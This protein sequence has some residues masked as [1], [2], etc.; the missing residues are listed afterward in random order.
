MGYPK[1]L[2]HFPIIVSSFY[3]PAQPVEAFTENSSKDSTSA[4]STRLHERCP[5]SLHVDGDFYKTCLQDCIWEKNHTL[6]E[7]Q[8]STLFLERIRDERVY[9][10]GASRSVYSISFFVVVILRN[11][12]KWNNHPQS[13]IG[14][15]SVRAQSPYV[16]NSLTRERGKRV[17]F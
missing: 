7:P 10:S 11:I 2:I 12:L 5:T 9:I 8:D 6:P 3:I 13:K 14:Q 4:Q 17:V 15:G 1:I 16:A